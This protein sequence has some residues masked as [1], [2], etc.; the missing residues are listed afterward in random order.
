MIIATSSY[1]VKPGTR[2]IVM[3][4]AKEFREY[5]ISCKGNIDYCP[6][7]SPYDDDMIINIEK[8]E[9]LEDVRTYARSNECKAFGAKRNEYLVEGSKQSGIYDT[10]PVK[11]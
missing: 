3:G 10:T 9:T 4:F 2:D 5:A 1:K 6:M 11:L 7:P 8:W